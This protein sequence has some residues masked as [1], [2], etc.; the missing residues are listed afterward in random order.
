MKKIYKSLLV[1]ITLV[2]MGHSAFARDVTD[3]VNDREVSSDYRGGNGGSGF[4][5]ENEIPKYFDARVTKVKVRHNERIDAIQFE[6]EYEN[7][8]KTKKSTFY[9]GSGG[10]ESSFTLSDGEF[11]NKIKIWGTDSSAS[12]GR[13]GRISFTTS[14]GKVYD[15]GETSNNLQQ[16]GQYTNQQIIGVWGREGT[17][18]DRLGIITAPA[19]DLQVIDIGLRDKTYESLQT[20]ST[21]T[22]SQVLFNDSSASQSTQ[23]SVAYT[24]ESSFSNSYSDTA[25]IT[26]TNNVTV[27]TKSDVFGIAEVSASISAGVSSQ[28]SL[29]VGRADSTSNNTTTTIK[30]DTNVAANSIVVAEATAYY[31]QEEVDYIMTVENNFG[32]E[33]FFVLG[34]FSGTNTTVFGSWTEI[35]TIN[36]GVIDIYSA[37]ENEYGYYEN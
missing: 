5:M 7:G 34:T 1:L 13:V 16:L 11:I 36:N 32:G 3:L 25:G 27:S 35:G 19:V 10:T 20:A 33:L 31:G 17:E 9:G 21:F 30:V 2:L 18:I 14:E 28:Q 24:E 15:Y 29:T 22:S 6:W 26:T 23:V 37:F 8:T 4:S 12:S